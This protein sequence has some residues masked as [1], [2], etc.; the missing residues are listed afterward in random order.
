[1]NRLELGLVPVSEVDPRVRGFFPFDFFNGVQSEVFEELYR[2]NNSLVLNAPTAS[3]KTVVFEL[4]ISRW[5]LHR[6]AGTCVVYLAPLKALCDERL[7][8]W[9]AKFRPV[10]LR[11]TMFSSDNACSARDISN[12]DVIIATPEKFESFLRKLSQNEQS[13]AWSSHFALIMIDEIHILGERRGATLE[14]IVARI[15]RA[16][17]HLGLMSRWICASATVSNV[18]DIATWLGASSV[19]FGNEFR[20]IPLDYHVVGVNAASSARNDF[21]VDAILNHEVFS[22]ISRFSDHRA[23]LVF[24][25]TRKSAIDAAVQ[26]ASDVSANRAQDLVF[27]TEEQM[28]ELQ[29]AAYQVQHNELRQLISQGVGFHSAE[30]GT[31]DRHL[32]E[33]LFGNS[34][35][36]VLF[37]TS[38]LAFGINLPAHLVIIKGTKQYDSDTGAMIDI[39]SM[40]LLQMI[41]RAGRPQFDSVGIAVVMTTGADVQQYRKLLEDTSPLQSQLMQPRVL[42]ELLNSEISSDS[43]SSLDSALDWLRHTFLYHIHMSQHRNETALVAML[44]TELE[45]LRAGGFVDANATLT[46]IEPTCMGRIVSRHQLR[47]NTLS[48]VISGCRPFWQLSH[49]LSALCVAIANEDDTF[50]LRLGDKKKLSLLLP[51][52][53]AQSPHEALRN[54]RIPWP[55]HRIDSTADKLSILIQAMLVGMERVDNRIINSACR[56]AHSFVELVELNIN[57]ESSHRSQQLQIGYQALRNVLVL[58]KA[59]QQRCITL[60]DMVMMSEHNLPVVFAAAEQG[61]AQLQQVTLQSRNFGLM[62]AQLPDVSAATALAL[63]ESGIHTFSHLE[64]APDSVLQR[65]AHSRLRPNKLK[66]LL[67]RVPAYQL[68]VETEPAQ[69][70]FKQVHITVEQVRSSFSSSTRHPFAL[71]AGTSDNQIVLFQRLY[72]DKQMTPT[73]L[74]ISFPSNQA[75]RVDVIDCHWMGVDV[76]ARVNRQMPAVATNPPRGVS[77]SSATQHQDRSETVVATSGITLAVGELRQTSLEE[78]WRGSSRKRKRT[79]L[80]QAPAVPAQSLIDEHKHADQM[81]AWPT[82]SS[83]QPL[84]PAESMFRAPTVSA[85][86]KPPRNLPWNQSAVRVREQAPSLLHPIVDR[87][88]QVPMVFDFLID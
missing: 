8:S 14:A 67:N 63:A 29:T 62:L 80:Q 47:M 83:F 39:D 40:T 72:W 51:S 30:L 25:P 26:F 12:I 20:P 52:K 35:L 66:G 58:N 81:P 28:V 54:P 76:E 34:L 86:Q 27:A 78:M 9:S 60:P 49:W 1:M 19:S 82:T 41:G 61:S 77:G 46:V 4:A 55:P 11:C 18:G 24:C 64:A 10:G 48:H 23:V 42:G 68:T 36:L 21:Q 56:I 15:R 13:F 37:C 43:V 65:T 45:G 75:L 50:R 16:Q 71:L 87:Q 79:T 3:G 88:P 33:Q 17:V 85:S 69:Q 53:R 38:T 84:Q 70:G 59:I 73:V 22:V 31:D 2:S 32:I 44:T 74:H 6:N 5:F 57:S 7:K